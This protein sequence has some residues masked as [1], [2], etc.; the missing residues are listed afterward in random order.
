MVSSRAE[1]KGPDW[2]G[3]SDALK[4]R[5][6]LCSILASEDNQFRRNLAV[7]AGGVLFLSDLGSE[8]CNCSPQQINTSRLVDAE[9]VCPS[10]WSGNTVKSG[11]TQGYGPD[12]ASLPS[13]MHISA[14]PMDGYISD[15]NPT[16]PIVVS[17]L[18]QADTLI[19]TGD[20]LSRL[21]LY[22]ARLLDHLQQ[23]V[24]WAFAAYMHMS[25]HVS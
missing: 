6:G 21:I 13:R 15:G 4:N 18:D 19:V 16:P 11:Y 14:P 9:E 3:L 10:N 25:K 17:V 7:K 20:T 5:S 23:A 8:Y 1:G 24:R 12:L 2:N 22:V